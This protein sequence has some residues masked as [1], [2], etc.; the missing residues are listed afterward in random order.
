MTRVFVRDAD[1]SFPNS[2]LASKEEAWAAKPGMKTNNNP[3]SEHSVEN[4]KLLGKRGDSVLD[5]RL[6][7]VQLDKATRWDKR[8]GQNDN[9]TTVADIS[10]W[11]CN[12]FWFSFSCTGHGRLQEAKRGQ[13]NYQ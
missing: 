5:R 1:D 10:P 9:F 6:Q 11:T 3:Y 13:N 7:L 8:V 2:L 4:I 12:G